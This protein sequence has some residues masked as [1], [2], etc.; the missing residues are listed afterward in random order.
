MISLAIWEKH[1]DFTTFPILLIVTIAHADKSGGEFLSVAE[2]LVAQWR[3]H[4]FK[5]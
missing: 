2:H 1:G 5:K 3:M 4:S